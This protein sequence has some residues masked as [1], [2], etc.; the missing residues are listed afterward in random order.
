M[1]GLFSYIFDTE[2]AYALQIIDVDADGRYFINANI[3]NEVRFTCHLSDII[4]RYTG[5]D[6]IEYK[7]P[8]C[9]VSLYL[10]W[11]YNYNCYD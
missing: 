9:E 6:E 3:G 5:L 1:I 10:R 8:G 11:N 7:T 4:R 2:S